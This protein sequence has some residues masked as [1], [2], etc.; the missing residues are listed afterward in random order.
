MR[1]PRKTRRAG[2][3]KVCYPTEL[4]ALMHA[5]WKNKRIRWHAY[6]CWACG[7]WHATKDTQLLLH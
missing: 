2:T 6:R 3:Y 4:S 7:W 5:T 1:C